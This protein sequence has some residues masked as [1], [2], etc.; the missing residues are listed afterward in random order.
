MIMTSTRETFYHKM[1]ISSF[2]FK[3]NICWFVNFYNLIDS[4]FVRDEQK[5]KTIFYGYRLI[6]VIRL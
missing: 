5:T 4:Q 3:N 6:Q 2:D 1:L